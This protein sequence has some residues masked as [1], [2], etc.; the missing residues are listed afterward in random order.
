MVQTFVLSSHLSCVIHTV[1]VDPEPYPSRHHLLHP[2]KHKACTGP[3]SFTDR[4]AQACTRWCKSSKGV[5]LQYGSSS[6]IRA[7]QMG[8][9]CQHE[10]AIVALIAYMSL[11]PSTLLH[12]RHPGV[13]ESSGFVPP[14]SHDH[15][16][17]SS[18]SHPTILSTNALSHS[19]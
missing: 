5:L 13:Y 2:V 3:P 15:P 18:L 4:G 11:L 16:H 10:S 6:P 19:L 7:Y 17:H 8:S 9:R 1:L 12:G 14:V